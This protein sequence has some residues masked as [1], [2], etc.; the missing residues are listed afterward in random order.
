EHGRFAGDVIALASESLPG[1]PLMVEVMHAGRRTAAGAS[2]LEEARARCRAQLAML[3]EELL[4]LSPARTPYSVTVSAA[5][6]AEAARLR[7]GLS[8]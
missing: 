1:E 5:L 4:S 7:Q 6:Q 8:R 2:S 3:P